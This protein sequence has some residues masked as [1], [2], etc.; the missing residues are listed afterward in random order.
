MFVGR[1]SPD[2]YAARFWELIGIQGSRDDVKR[3]ADS[4][5]ETF[6]RKLLLIMLKLDSE[7]RNKHVLRYPQLPRSGFRGHYYS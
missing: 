3:L 2:P 6:W 7:F 5:I 1:W 4:D